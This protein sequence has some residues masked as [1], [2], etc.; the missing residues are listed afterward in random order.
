MSGVVS[1]NCEN[2]NCGEN[3]LCNNCAQQ[4]NFPRNNPN[5]VI[6][7][8]EAL[9]LLYANPA[10]VETEL[11]QTNTQFAK[12]FYDELSNLFKVSKLNDSNNNQF[13]FSTALKTYRFDLVYNRTDR[14]LHV[15]G[16][17]ITK[18]ISLAKEL[19]NQRSFLN[20]VLDSIPVDIAMFNAKHQYTYMNRVA[21]K[22][23][24][25]RNWLINKTDF[26][27]CDLKGIDNAMAMIRHNNFVEA[28]ITK[29]EVR[30]IDEI[31]KNGHTKHVVRN[32]HPIVKDNKVIDVVGYG[33]DLTEQIEAQNK[34][35]KTYDLLF[36]SQIA[37]KQLL[38]MYVHDVKHP[39][40]NIEGL[41]DEFNRDDYADPAN[42]F[43][44]DGLMLSYNQLK[45]NFKGLTSKFEDS[46]RLFEIDKQEIDIQAA[47]LNHSHENR[48][49][50]LTKNEFRFTPGSNYK[51]V[52]YDFMLKRIVSSFF[53][54]LGSISS[55]PVLNLNV[56]QSLGSQYHSI[57][58][59]IPWLDL[60]Q[61]QLLSIHSALKDI[62]LLSFST[63]NNPI[64]DI[65]CILNCTGGN[66]DI[67]YLED[68]MAF[69]LDFPIIQLNDAK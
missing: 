17:D 16:T 21:V 29:E 38:T 48:Q 3:N 44:I 2:N 46:F 4:Y 61:Q 52:F 63:S 43:I 66:F 56:L 57:K 35:Q 32:Y 34:L 30:F 24:D 7:Y 19:E 37:L 55:T 28:L 36:T 59:I 64:T 6:L 39:M 22:N 65:A 40:T 20:H 10:A 68:K 23:D 50:S 47:L 11:L 53:K 45:N 41:I 62:N 54:V 9:E 42:Q 1:S 13:Q 18:E 58:I 12:C 31:Q 14:V 5:P 51:I 60:N 49:N 27:Y 26:D 67:T 33:I 8:N 69:L 25:L 15:Y